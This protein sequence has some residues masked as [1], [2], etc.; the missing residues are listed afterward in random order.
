MLGRRNARFTDELRPQRE[1]S[2]L[3]TSRETGLASRLRDVREDLYGEFGAQ[4]LA[5]A[6]ELPLQTWLNYEAGVV[7]PGHVKLRVQVVTRVTAR[8]PANG[9]GKKYDRRVPSA[10]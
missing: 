7:V 1:E 9:E 10:F 6:L 5:D 3:D 8:W 2:N 4:F